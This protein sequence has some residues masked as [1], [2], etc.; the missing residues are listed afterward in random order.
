VKSFLEEKEVL[1]FIDMF[2]NEKMNY[3]GDNVY[4]FYYID[5]INRNKFSIDDE[6]SLQKKCITHNKPFWAKNVRIPHPCKPEEEN[7]IFA[8]IKSFYIVPLSIDN[9]SFGTIIFSHNKYIVY[10]SIKK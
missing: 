1:Y 10:I 3:Y 5:L 4:K 7:I 8:G 9:T 6:H 2:N